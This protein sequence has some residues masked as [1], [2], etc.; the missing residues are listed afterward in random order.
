VPFGLIGY[1]NVPV[2]SFTPSEITT[3]PATISGGVGLISGSRYLAVDDGDSLYIADS[4][5]NAVRYIDSS[6]L[7]TT[8]AN[9][10]A[11]PVGVTIDMFGEVYF[12]EP[13]VDKIFEI[14]GYGPVVQ[15]SGTGSDPCAAGA[16]C[17]LNA[18]SIGTP[19]EMSTSDGNSVFFTDSH[20]GAALS[21]VQPLPATLIRLYDPFPYQTTPSGAFAVDGNATLYSSWTTGT[22]CEIVAQSLYNAENSNIAFNKVAGGR[23]CGFAGDGGRA[24]GA[25]MGTK[26]GQIAF[27][28]AGNMYFTDTANNRVRRVDA[29]TGVIRTIAGT[30][31]VGRRGDGGPA[32]KAALGVPTGLAVDSQG[33]VYVLT[34]SDKTSTGTAQVVRELTT[35]GMLNFADRTHATSSAPLIVTVSN[36]GTSTLVF[37]SGTISGNNHAD[38]VIDAGTT[39]CNFKAGNYLYVGQSCQIGVVFTPG[40]IGSR[41]STLK[42]VDNTVNAVSKVLLSGKGL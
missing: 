20:E 8:I 7:M 38:F 6:L 13:S 41:S 36:T 11:P 34:P 12:S 40:A 3:V 1:S 33:Q 23:T 4:G 29:Y 16:G 18:E 25:E 27:D 30:G 39:N 37:K 19:G 9:A 22:A 14:Y 24:T 28:L 2:V 5:N 32:T 35:T 31:T 26:I 17:S 15:T 42:L 10:S 21:V